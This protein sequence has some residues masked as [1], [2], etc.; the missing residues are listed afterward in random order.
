MGAEYGLPPKTLSAEARRAIEQYQWPGNVRELRNQIER[1]VLL[2]DGSEVRPEHFH[3]AGGAGER[4]AGSA[5]TVSLDVDGAE[6]ALQVA[7]PEL[8]FSLDALE[9]EVIRQALSKHAG[10]VSQTA[11]YLGITRHTL[12]YRLRKYDLSAEA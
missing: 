9:R 11:R 5:A 4:S 10:N 8:P 1:I 7:L 2:E 6:G 12:I 3:F